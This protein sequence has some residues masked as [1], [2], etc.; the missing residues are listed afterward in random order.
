MKKFS[1]SFNQ[2]L[3]VPVCMESS[4]LVAQIEPAFAQTKVKHTKGAGEVILKNHQLITGELPG[5]IECLLFYQ[6]SYNQN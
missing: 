4:E 1:Y 2:M 3:K 6:Q 5:I